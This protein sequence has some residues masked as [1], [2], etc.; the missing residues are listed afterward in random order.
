MEDKINPKQFAKDLIPLVEAYC[1]IVKR[2]AKS[3]LVS[4]TEY[5]CLQLALFAV[6]DYMA[7]ITKKDPISFGEIHLDF[8]SKE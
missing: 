8:E 1:E 7:R 3:R 2:V 4:L 6:N 5:E